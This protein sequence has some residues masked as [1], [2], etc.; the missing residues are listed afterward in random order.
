MM[1]WHEWLVAA[2]AAIAAVTIIRLAF[3]TF[4]VRSL[5]PISITAPGPNVTPIAGNTECMRALPP[6]IGATER[7]ERAGR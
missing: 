1:R 3:T 2:A 6:D 7:R 4:I 5:T